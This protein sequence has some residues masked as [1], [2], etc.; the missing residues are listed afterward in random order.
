MGTRR[1]LIL[2]TALA[3]LA[4]VSGCGSCTRKQDDAPAPAPPDKLAANEVV[5]GKERAFG[6]PLPRAARVNVR[7]D[8]TVHV[9][10]AIEREDVA[11]F[12]RARVNDGS[13]VVG[14]SITTLANVVPRLDPAR[15]LTVEVR[16]VKLADGTRSEMVVRDVTPLA[17]EP[18][19]TNEQRWQK[20]G[21]TSQGKVS[22]PSHLQ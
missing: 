15:V 1:R 22:D 10:L 7:F 6:L 4:W 13:V 9:V 8:T 11:A 21:L 12:V 19:L 17:P 5:E 3:L 2:G 16:S 14:P 20:A 18:G